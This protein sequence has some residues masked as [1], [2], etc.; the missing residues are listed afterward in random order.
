MVPSTGIKET[1]DLHRTI[2]ANEENLEL[3]VPIYVLDDG[4]GTNDYPLSHHTNQGKTS[5]FTPK[6]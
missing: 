4:N 2:L 1:V 5:L 3:T 6:I